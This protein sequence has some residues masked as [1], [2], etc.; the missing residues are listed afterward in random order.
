MLGKKKDYP[1]IVA[2]KGS[3]ATPL[4]LIYV[5][6]RKVSCDGGSDSGHPLV[7]LEIKEDSVVCPYCSKTFTVKKAKVAKK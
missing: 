6:S 4:E 7:Y 3:S 5:N 1:V 2:K